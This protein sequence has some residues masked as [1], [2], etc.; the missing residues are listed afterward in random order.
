MD[1]GGHAKEAV[2]Q[3]T[4]R[5]S[6]STLRQEPYH[7]FP[8]LKPRSIYLKCF[9]DIFFSTRYQGCK[10]L[11]M[12]FKQRNDQHCIL[13]QSFW[14]QCMEQNRRFKIMWKLFK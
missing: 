13:E 8:E 11:L 7:R 4:P 6:F 9:M 12:S 1:L 3:S 10:Y 2:H 14:L 5:T